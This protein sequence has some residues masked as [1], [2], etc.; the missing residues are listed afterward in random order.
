MSEDSG[1]ASVHV[2]MG[3]AHPDIRDLRDDDF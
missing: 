1:S 3:N 2:P